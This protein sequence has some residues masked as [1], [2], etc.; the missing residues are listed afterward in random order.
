MTVKKLIQRKGSAL[1]YVRDNATVWKAL[2]VMEIHNI[3]AILILDDDGNLKGIF[4][5]RDYARK[6]ILKGRAA[7]KTPVVDVMTPNV[8]TVSME[9]SLVNCMR[10]M[11]NKHIR[12]LPVMDDNQLLGMVTIRDVVKEI[13]SDQKG[14]IRELEAYIQGSYGGF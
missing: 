4:S 10:I 5:E 11:S 8:I 2:E 1:Y 3:G 7:A 9:D 12:H 14:K 13:I 6:G